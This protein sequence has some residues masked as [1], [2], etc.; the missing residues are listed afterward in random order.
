MLKCP[1]CGTDNL[2]SA[3]FCRGC[4]ARMNLDEIKPDDFDKLDNKKNST[5]IQNIIGG[6]II[7]VLV[8]G[9][10]IGLIFP[11]PGSLSTTEA[12]QAAALEKF[13]S[14]PSFTATDQELT[15]FAN[16]MKARYTGED[17]DPL[18]KSVTIRCLGDSQVK[19]L[20]KATYFGFLPV[21]VS[22]KCSVNQGDTISLMGNQV[23][24]GLLPLPAGME[25][26]FFMPLRNYGRNM[27]SDANQK[28]KNLDIGVGEATLKHG[29]VKL[30]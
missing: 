13:S 14:S 3:V 17:T 12:G 4:G 29:R 7:G 30:K 28:I 19:V 1:K 25:E 26:Q 11:T 27:M 22:V 24:L 2:L 6:A 21:T 10:L 8:I 20:V 16:A 5:T 9:F 18:F 15:D 23:K